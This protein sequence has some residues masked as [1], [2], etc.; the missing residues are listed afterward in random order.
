MFI[1][2]LPKTHVNALF[3]SALPLPFPYAGCW[4]GRPYSQPSTPP[5]K[6]LGAWPKGT[7]ACTDMSYKTM[8]SNS[9]DAQKYTEMEMMIPA[10]THL[11]VRVTYFEKEGSFL[12]NKNFCFESHLEVLAGP[13]MIWHQSLACHAY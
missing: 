3:E 7:E 12:S 4:D 10:E 11:E 5:P 13:W 6:A 9:D 2:M 1:P 8:T